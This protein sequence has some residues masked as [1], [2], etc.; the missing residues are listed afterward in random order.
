MKKLMARISI[1]ITTL[2]MAATALAAGKIYWGLKDVVPDANTATWSYIGS[3]FQFYDKNLGSASAWWEPMFP[4]EIRTTDFK[5]KLNI[6]AQSLPSNRLHLGVSATSDFRL[7]PFD[8]GVFVTSELGHTAED[9]KEITVTVPNTPVNPGSVYRITITVQGMG[10]SYFYE[11][12]EE[13]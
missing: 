11:A 2:L 9:S 5:F 7:T 4:A 3:G 13:E 8:T 12:L 1:F 6:R 10:V